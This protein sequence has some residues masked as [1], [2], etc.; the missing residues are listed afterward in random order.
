MVSHVDFN[1]VAPKDRKK[2]V[3]LKAISNSRKQRQLAQKTMNSIRHDK[4][5]PFET[6][7]SFQTAVLNNSAEFNS[8]CRSELFQTSRYCR[9][10]VEFNS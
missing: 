1:S 4:S 7:L 2:F 9:D 3:L 5:T 6:K 8:A 10:Q